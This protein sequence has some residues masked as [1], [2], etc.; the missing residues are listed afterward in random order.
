[1]KLCGCVNWCRI[2]WLVV[3]LNLL[4]LPNFTFSQ[5]LPPVLDIGVANQHAEVDSVFSY[6]LPSNVFKDENND[7]ITYSVAGLPAGLSFQA[8]SRLVSGTPVSPGNFTI[9]VS[10]SDGSLEQSTSFVLYV[11]PAGATYAAFTMNT[12]MGCNFRQITF[13]NLSKGA[14]SYQWILGNGNTSSVSDPQAIYNTPGTYTVTLTTN[15]GHSHSEIIRIFPRPSPGIAPV[16][17]TGCEPFDLTLTSNGAPISVPATSINGQTVGAI[18]GGSDFY[19][20]WY[21]FEQHPAIY[22]TVLPDVQVNDL[23]DGFYNV[24]LEVTDANG[25]QGS[26]VVNNLFEVYDQPE[27]SFTYYKSDNCAPSLTNFYNNSN[28]NN[29]QLANS[30]WFINGTELADHNDTVQY[31]FTGYGQFPV[32]L[33][34]SSARG[35]VSGLYHDTI[36]FNNNNTADFLLDN[37]YCVGDTINL[38]AINSSGAVSY[39]WDLNNN[40]SVEGT[41]ATFSRVFDQAGEYPLKLTVGFNDDCAIVVLKTIRVDEAT[42]DFSAQVQYSCTNNNYPVN[43]SSTS[44]TAL[45]RNIVSTNWYLVE[46]SSLTLLSMQ[47]NFSRTFNQSGT[48]TIRLEVN[49]VDGCTASIEKIVTLQ[50]PSVNITVSGA[51]SGCLPAGASHFDAAFNSLY[52]SPISYHWDFGDGNTGSGQNT[53]HTYVA[54]GSYNVRVTVQTSSGCSY[55]TVRLN[56]V[57]LSDQPVLGAINLV[58]HPGDCFNQGAA[59]QVNYPVGTDQLFLITSTGEEII[60]NPGASPYT[61]QYEFPDTG[62]FTVGIMAAR[63]G[64]ISDTVS[65][66]NI[67]AN[68]PRASFNSDQTT[69]C[70]DPPYL[71]TFTNNSA[72]TD[73]ATT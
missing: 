34:T 17:T 38:T 41:T 45:N 54:T 18:S 59:L 60:P 13:T 62:N 1:M 19:H 56:A 37:L 49:S 72:Y 11:H 6:T 67:R 71:T 7:P 15:T 73:P 39:A 46:G 3:L 65:V 14:S 10:G 70:D 61:Y 26:K 47:P 58:Q 12:Q 27:A 25:C 63:Y 5:N 30:R 31:N 32:S 22:N 40:G 36:R 29:S 55:Q 69:F 64:C 68:E 50:Q 48:I 43:F 53:S 57:R 16:T 42:A 24:M 4:F 23:A 20:Y 51:T 66:S 9:T 52:E 35:C 28:V 2:G 44:N 8:D 33:Q 21:F